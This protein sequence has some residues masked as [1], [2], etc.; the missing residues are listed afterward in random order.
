MALMMAAFFLS[1][2]RH[3]RSHQLR[4]FVLASNAHV[5]DLC[6]WEQAIHLGLAPREAL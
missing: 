2:Q 1:R 6:C 4:C 5:Y 3:H